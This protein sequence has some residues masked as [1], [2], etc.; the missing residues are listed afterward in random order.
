MHDREEIEALIKSVRQSSEN[1]AVDFVFTEITV[2]I[3]SC[4]TAR[5]R[6]RL[7][8]DAFSAIQNAE[9]ALGTAKK[10]MRRFRKSHPTEYREMMKGTEHLH[11]ELDDLKQINI[12]ININVGSLRLY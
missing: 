11:G 1:V 9:H 10:L 5:T 3:T 8:F 12:N 2:G 7:G 4:K 6:L